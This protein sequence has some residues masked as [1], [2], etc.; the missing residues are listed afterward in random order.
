MGYE[1]APVEFAD[2]EKNGGDADKEKEVKLI[3]I[4]EEINEV[5][6]QNTW[7]GEVSKKVL[8]NA[9]YKFKKFMQEFIYCA[10]IILGITD[11]E[12]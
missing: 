8:E 1:E 6:K 11:P 2:D 7:H 10:N 12:T 5:T 9:N 4:E 3:N